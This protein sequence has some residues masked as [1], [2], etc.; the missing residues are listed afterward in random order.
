ML[1]KKYNDYFR[2]NSKCTYLDC[3]LYERTRREIENLDRGI[4]IALYNKLI[5]D[6]DVYM[7]IPD[8]INSKDKNIESIENFEDINSKKIITVHGKDRS[9]YISCLRYYLDNTEDEIIA[10]SA[11]DSWMTDESRSD[12]ISNIDLKGRKI[13]FFGLRSPNELNYIK[14]V[15][16]K[17]YSLD[18]SLPVTCTLENTFIGDIKQKPKTIIFDI[19]NDDICIN[20]TL[21]VDNL[22]Y[23]REILK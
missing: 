21:L 2:K 9:E 20:Y 17:I 6:M 5:K 16:D 12:V 4:Y 15:K 8:Y 10:L 11:G 19:F 23:I 7:I 18:T 14:E 3:S 1:N 13:H 22:K